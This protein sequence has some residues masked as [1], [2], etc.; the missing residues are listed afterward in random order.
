MSEF[1]QQ[2]Q[3]D[4]GQYSAQLAKHCVWNKLMERMPR[5]IQKIRSF[6]SDEAVQKIFA[7]WRHL[8]NSTGKSRDLLFGFP[9]TIRAIRETMK[10]LEFF[11]ME[12]PELPE[13]ISEIISPD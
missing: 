3:I 4:L 6:P 5:I 8:T 10:I 7:N 2:Q 9:E 12:F 13:S 11:E 1:T